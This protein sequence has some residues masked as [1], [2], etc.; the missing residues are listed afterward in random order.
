MVQAPVSVAAVYTVMATELT[1]IKKTV[2]VDTNVI[3][4]VGSR[5]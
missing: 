4:W 5:Q 1:K 3:M 2:V